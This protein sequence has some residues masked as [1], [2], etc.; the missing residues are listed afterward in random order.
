MMPSVCVLESQSQSG[1][2]SAAAYF[3][4]LRQATGR[5]NLNSG[6]SELLPCADSYLPREVIRDI[7]SPTKCN[8]G[9]AWRAHHCG[10]KCHLVEWITLSVREVADDSLLHSEIRWAAEYHKLE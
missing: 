5:G 2:G 7:A 6:P 1:G 8:F 10:I 4:V 9:L 3:D